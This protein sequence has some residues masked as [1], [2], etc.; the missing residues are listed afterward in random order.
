[1]EQLDFQIDNQK[2]KI[3]LQ[4]QLQKWTSKIVYMIVDNKIELKKKIL[5]DYPSWQFL[6]ENDLKETQY[7]M[8]L[9]L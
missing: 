2:K 1:M 8:I 3:Y 4:Y 7:M 9:K 6:P 5:G